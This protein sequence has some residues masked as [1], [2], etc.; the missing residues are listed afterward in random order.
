LHWAIVETAERPGNWTA[1]WRRWVRVEDALYGRDERRQETTMK[2]MLQTKGKN[3]NKI[4]TERTKREK[5]QNEKKK[6][7]AIG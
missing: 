5:L 7:F 2:R 1:E 4:G 6:K 3:R